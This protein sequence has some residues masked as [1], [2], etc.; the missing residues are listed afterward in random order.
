M[1]A[2]ATFRQNHCV[3][4]AGQEP[5]A[6]GVLT[7]RRQIRGSAYGIAAQVMAVRIQRPAAGAR[8]E[9]DGGA[10]RVIDDNSSTRS[11]TVLAV[12]SIVITAGPRVRGRENQ[13]TPPALSR[14]SETRLERC[15]EAR[16]LGHRSGGGK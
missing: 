16:V 11:S 5:I 8:R 12:S 9:R 4:P 2:T 10:L 6:L 15:S 13:P 14:R 7:G 3:Q 1:G